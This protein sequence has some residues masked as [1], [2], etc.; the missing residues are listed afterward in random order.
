MYSYAFLFNCFFKMMKMFQ[1]ENYLEKVLIH[2]WIHFNNNN[3][4]A[5]STM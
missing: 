5:A 4:E 3:K 1:T 2:K